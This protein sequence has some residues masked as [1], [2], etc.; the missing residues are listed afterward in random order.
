MGEVGEPR[1]QSLIGIS[2]LSFLCLW[3]VEKAENLQGPRGLWA[4]SLAKSS[5]SSPA[6]TPLPPTSGPVGG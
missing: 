3:I 2:P 6:V 1:V 4:G 5:A